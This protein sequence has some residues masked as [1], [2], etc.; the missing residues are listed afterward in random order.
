MYMASNAENESAIV[1]LKGVIQQK[2]ETVADL[3]D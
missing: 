3:H 2:D 1:E